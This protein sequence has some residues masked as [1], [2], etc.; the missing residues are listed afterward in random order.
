MM[1]SY[2][3]TVGHFLTKDMKPEKCEMREGDSKI[4][5]RLPFV[6]LF[7]DEKVF[8]VDHAVNRQNGRIYA[9]SKP[10]TDVRL[11]SHLASVMVL[12]A[13]TLTTRFLSSLFCKG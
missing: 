10:N 9:T 11:S 5:E 1:K 8:T 4:Q 2:K 3:K 7:T 13:I 12:G 6:H